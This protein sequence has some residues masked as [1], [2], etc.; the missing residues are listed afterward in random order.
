ML[1]A[2]KTNVTAVPES[3]TSPS[4]KKVSFYQWQTPAHRNRR[5]KSQEAMPP[6]ELPAKVRALSHPGLKERTGLTPLSKKVA[7]EN[8]TRDQYIG[9][10][11]A[12]RRDDLDRAGRL[13]DVDFRKHGPLGFKILL[14]RGDKST[15]RRVIV[16]ET[17]E[18]CEAFATLRPLDELVAV[19]G[20]LLIEMDPEA[21]GELVRRL[22]SL[23]PLR[24]T[25]AKGDGR[26]GAF[27]KQTDERK[28]QAVGTTKAVVDAIESRG[29]GGD[30]NPPTIAS[31]GDGQDVFCG[32]I[33]VGVT[34][35]CDCAHQ[36]LDDED[37]V[38]KPPLVRE[39]HKKKTHSLKERTGR[40]AL[41]HPPKPPPLKKRHSAL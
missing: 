1:R 31:R 17:F 13:Y 14:A 23:R 16:D 10:A 34:L 12:E 2:A 37:E 30:E 18:Y 22:R 3:L 26:D 9:E 35:S 33:C 39:K 28:G 19:Q 6:S 20:D 41:K 29:L 4:S 24:L 36:Q 11:Y 38:T 21:F 32:A 40:H 5:S 8:L 27:R 15:R 7:M 25:F